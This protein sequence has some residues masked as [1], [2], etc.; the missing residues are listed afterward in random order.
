[1]ANDTGKA[2]EADLALRA[3][4]G[5]GKA[6]AE[7]VR[8]FEGP[9]YRLCRR[10]LPPADAEE[11]VQDVFMRAFL[12]GSRFDLTRPLSP[13]LLTIARR[14][15]VDKLRYK[16]VRPEYASDDIVV[17]VPPSAED[18]VAARQELR[19]LNAALAQLAE[20]PREALVL[21][22]V[23]GLAYRDIAEV[24]GVP[25]GTVMTWL[26]RTRAHLRTLLAAESAAPGKPRI[27]SGVSP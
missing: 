21:F 15:C 11:A 1:M 16:G 2:V 25:I 10:Y 27:E 22:H 23:E 6:F 8:L 17:A 24:L 14:L 19:H 13:W 9:V 18:E 7:L 5:D 26:H 12:H 20:G 4:H 3:F